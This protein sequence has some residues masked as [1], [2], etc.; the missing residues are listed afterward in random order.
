MEGIV[1][2]KKE[3]V[4]ELNN[5]LI[6]LL[7]NSK[8]I[9]S[10]PATEIITTA[11]KA[12]VLLK[13]LLIKFEWL[14][15]EENISSV[16]SIYENNVNINELLNIAKNNLTKL[17]D[18]QIHTETFLSQTFVDETREYNKKTQE[19]FINSNAK[20][21]ELDGKILDYINN[22]VINYLSQETDITGIITKFINI[23]DSIENIYEFDILY[24]TITNSVINILQDKNASDEEINII[25]N[26]IEEKKSASLTNLKKIHEFNPKNTFFKTFGLIPITR[27]MSLSELSNIIFKKKLA[28]IDA[29][30]AECKRN[31]SDILLIKKHLNKG[32]RYNFLHLLD[33]VVSKQFD[34]QNKTDDGISTDIIDR[35][36]TLEFINEKSEKWNISYE[37]L[38]NNDKHTKILIIEELYTEQFHLLSNGLGMTDEKY[39]FLNKFT[40]QPLLSF[41]KNK[42]YESTRV[43]N[44]NTL[45]NKAIVKGMFLPM[46]ADL[47]NIKIKSQSIDPK[48]LRNHIFILIIAKYKELSLAP[49]KS[50]YDFSKIA[51]DESYNYIFNTTIMNEYYKYLFNKTTVYSFEH[52]PISEIYMSFL[53]IMNTYQRDFKKKMHDTLMANMP[54]KELF[55][56][57]N[58]KYELEKIFTDI[59]N[60]VLSSI[61]T[62]ESN[63]FQSVMYKL[64]L[65]K[66]S[67][68]N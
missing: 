19:L 49:I 47:E 5:N 36:K 25:I 22:H 59:T 18:K 44:Y 55:A 56:D 28:S 65:F 10:G 54:K 15:S 7:N 31:N 14:K 61:I 8:E 41:V 64:S 63:L 67:I 62:N 48:Y 50:P 9:F 46:K 51:H 39:L 1:S 4:S 11:E 16:F 57:E 45:I 13:D 58:A 6:H 60:S 43:N 53:Y 21:R 27:V 12:L 38:L 35:Y 52:A 20:I 17:F 30:I 24:E 3:L 32:I 29:F 2:K 40:L 37:L 68:L 34:K 26:K 42:R 23:I 33:P 66:L